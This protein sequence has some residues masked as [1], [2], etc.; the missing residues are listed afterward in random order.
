MTDLNPR[1][2]DWKVGWEVEVRVRDRWW[3]GTVTRME[4]AIAHVHVPELSETVKVSVRAADEIRPAGTW[5]P[6]LFGK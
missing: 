1:P 4:G 6:W 2:K 3:R 5:R